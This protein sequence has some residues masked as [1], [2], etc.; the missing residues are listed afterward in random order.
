MILGFLLYTG[1]KVSIRLQAIFLSTATPVSKIMCNAAVAPVIFSVVEWSG[2][3]LHPSVVNGASEEGEA[4]A[5]KVN[6]VSVNN[7]PQLAPSITV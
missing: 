5:V 7:Y 3:R 6:V 2:K 1:S 4:Q